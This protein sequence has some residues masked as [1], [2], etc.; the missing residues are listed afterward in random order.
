MNETA[1]AQIEKSIEALPTE[2]QL[3]L[4]SHVADKLR[5]SAKDE[6]EF[7]AQLAEMAADK[8]IQTELRNIEQDFEVTELGGLSG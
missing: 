3:L 5:K 8:Q 6:F 2:D 4:I 7:E 1:L